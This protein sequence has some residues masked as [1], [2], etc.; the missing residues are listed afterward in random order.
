MKIISYLLT[1]IC[2]VGNMIHLYWLCH[3]YFQYEVSSS[4]TVEYPEMITPPSVSI[5][6]HAHRLL[7]WKK[8]TDEEKRQILG[9][10]DT[11][12]LYYASFPCGG[13]RK[14]STFIFRE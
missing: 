8:M 9:C 13:G 12:G 5:R 4:V 10:N 14:N 6:L 1:T 2:L 11:M 3:S 7:L